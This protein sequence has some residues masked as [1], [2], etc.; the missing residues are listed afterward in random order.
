MFNVVVG[1]IADQQYMGDW[2]AGVQITTKYTQLRSID[3]TNKNASTVW[4]QLYN[5]ASGATGVPFGEYA[6][7]T[8][9]TFSLTDRRFPAG[10]YVR[11]VSSQGG[12]IIGTTDIK[13]CAAYEERP[14]V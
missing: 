14:Y 7:P 2:L 11:A 6:L 13:I 9:S 4:I 10:L 5:S 8:N 12:S 3:V 1:Y